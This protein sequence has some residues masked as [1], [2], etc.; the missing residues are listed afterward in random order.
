MKY[1]LIDPY[2]DTLNRVAEEVSQTEIASAYIQGVIDRMFELAAGKGGSESDSRQM[3][4][5]AAPQL[6]VSKRIVTIDL[7]AT[8]A[9]QTQSL[10]EFINPKIVHRSGEL[11]VGREAC[12]STGNICGI[13]DRSSEVVMVGYDRNGESISR[14]LVGFVARIAQ[15]ETDHL[16]GIRFPD[17]IPAD[18]PE[19]LHWVEHARFEDYR[20]N[21]ASWDILCERKTWDDFKAGI[22]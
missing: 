7:T 6:G 3:V 5:L 8:G 4:G 10:Q 15:H 9:N 22:R 20:N 2:S 13:V 12:W 11:V 17:R 1:D 14:T 18:Q 19:R 21:W 16:D